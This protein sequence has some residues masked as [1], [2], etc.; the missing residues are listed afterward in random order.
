MQCKGLA[1]P[2][3]LSDMVHIWIKVVYDLENLVLKILK[4]KANKAY[5]KHGVLN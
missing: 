2:L 5:Y 1:L 3:I 4:K